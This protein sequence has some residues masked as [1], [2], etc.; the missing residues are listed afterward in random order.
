MASNHGAISNEHDRGGS[1]RWRRHISHTAQAIAALIVPPTCLVCRERLSDADSLCSSCW[2]QLDFIRQPYCDRLGLPM[3]FGTSE[4][5]IS[6]AAVARPPAYDR[7]RAVARF[8]GVMRELVH[9]FK[10]ADRHDA[11]RLFVR[12]MMEAGHELLRDADIVV[13]VPLARSRLLWRRYNQAAILAADI[14]AASG[15]DYG[16]TVLQRT[17]KTPSQVGLTPD[18]RQRNVAGAFAVPAAQARQVRGRRVLLIDDVIT[19]G[20][21]VEAC[22]RVLRRSGASHVDVLAL[23]LVT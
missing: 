14:A 1:A 17:R 16:P 18:Q 23:G 10:Y 22:V 3:P 8:D 21:T 13:P 5:M 12:W 9:A 7:A 20:A 15:L 4:M 19:T 11:R 6:A 2:R